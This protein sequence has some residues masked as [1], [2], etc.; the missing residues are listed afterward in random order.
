VKTQ[1]R[2]RASRDGIRLVWQSAPTAPGASL[3][4]LLQVNIA[5]SAAHVL[6][7]EPAPVAKLA[8]VSAPEVVPTV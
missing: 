7:Q 5:V 4:E 2:Q 1:R 3:D 8:A 6:G